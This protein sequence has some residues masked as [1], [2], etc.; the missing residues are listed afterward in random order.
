M[1]DFFHTM[2]GQLKSI[3]CVNRSTHGPPLQSIVFRQWSRVSS[4]ELKAYTKSGGIPYLVVCDSKDAQGDFESSVLVAVH[5]DLT[6]G[7]L[8]SHDHHV[9]NHHSWC[10]GHA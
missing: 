7:V 10:Q 8:L 4:L 5:M 6:C 1:W 9:L 2:R 3:R